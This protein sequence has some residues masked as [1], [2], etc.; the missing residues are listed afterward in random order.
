M[1]V[2]WRATMLYIILIPNQFK[3]KQMKKYFLLLIVLCGLTAQAQYNKWA[4]SAELGNHYVADESA[5]IT[6][7]W[8]HYGAD[9]RYSLSDRFA[10]G[11]T[12]GY[13]N[14]T[15]KDFDGYVSETNYT[16]LN[17]EAT[18]EL[19]DILNIKSK[20]FNLLGHGGPG[21]SF[22]RNDR[23]NEDVFNRKSVV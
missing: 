17:L 13:D 5:L 3:L 12:G 22:I 1:L 9:V 2:T 6:D 19:F 21:I 20:R 15:L 4:V 11:I 18:V 7:A 8:N 14:L 10:I 23:Y 16:R